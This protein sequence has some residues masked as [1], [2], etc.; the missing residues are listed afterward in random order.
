M[1]LPGRNFLKCLPRDEVRSRLSTRFS[2]FRHRFNRDICCRPISW[3]S[4]TQDTF[5]SK[6]YV[7]QISLY[8]PCC[9]VAGRATSRIVQPVNVVCGVS[10]RPRCAG[11][12]EPLAGRLL[13]SV[14]AGGA[15]IPGRQDGPRR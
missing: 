6:I 13:P 10:G 4:Y 14:V 11:E 7:N 5:L 1:S 2:A 15:W 9:D 8:Q 3:T 12:L